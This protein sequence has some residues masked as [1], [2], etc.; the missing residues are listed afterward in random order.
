M[1]FVFLSPSWTAWREH[2]WKSHAVTLRCQPFTGDVILVIQSYGSIHCLFVLVS[3]MLSFDEKTCSLD[4]AL[5]AGTKALPP[6]YCQCMT[7]WFQIFLSLSFPF[8][9]Q[10]LCVRLEIKLG[11]ALRALAFR[12]VPTFISEDIWLL[13]VSAWIQCAGNFISVGVL[14]VR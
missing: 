9:S 1:S 7:R 5:S 13:Y 8:V 12:G 2:I 10:R 11:C 4:C 6:S 14:F 3:T